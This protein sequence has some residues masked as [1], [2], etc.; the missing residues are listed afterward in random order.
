MSS[1]TEGTIGWR[2]RNLYGL[3]RQ[4][5]LGRQSV[6]HLIGSGV[7][8]FSPSASSSSG[9]GV[10]RNATGTDGP[11]KINPTAIP[12]YPKFFGIAV[13]KVLDGAAGR[14][15]VNPIDPL[16]RV[17]M[18]KEQARIKGRVM[19]RK[20]YGE[21]EDV[22]PLLKSPVL[23]PEPGE[24]TDMDSVEI[25]GLGKR[26]R[27]A[28]EGEMT[29]EYISNANKWEDIKALAARDLVGKG[30]AVTRDD[31]E[32]PFISIRHVDGRNL[33]ISNC[34]YPDFSDI[35]H[36][37][38]LRVLTVPQLLAAIPQT[39]SDKLK[40]AFGE[41]LAGVLN[42]VGIVQ[43]PNLNENTFMSG[44]K[45]AILDLEIITSDPEAREERTNKH[46]NI[47][48]GA[49]D[50]KKNTPPAGGKIVRRTRMGLY[51]CK[52]VVGTDIVYDFGPASAQKRQLYGGSANPARV[53]SSFNIVAGDMEDMK[54][55][56]RT[57]AV[58]G[59]VDAM[60]T[61]WYRLQHAIN[62][63]VPKGFSIDVDAI[64]EIN[65]EGPNGKKMGPN[66]IM[67]LFFSRGIL[68]H[69]SSAISDDRQVR[70]SIEVLSGKMDG[71]LQE[72]WTSFMNCMEIIRQTMG[73]NEQT[74]ASSA[75]PKALTTL[76]N[77]AEAG[78][79]NALS[80]LI[81]AIQRLQVQ[82]C[83]SVML[84]AQGLVKSA[85]LTGSGD[86]EL[87][88][89][90]LGQGT[91][92]V[93]SEGPCIDRYTLGAVIEAGPTNE[94]LTLFGE[95]LTMSVQQALITPADINML[96]TIKN[97]KQRQLF[98]DVRIKQAKEAQQQEKKADVEYNAQVQ[99]QSAQAAEE[100][101]RQTAK[102][103]FDLDV[104]LEKLKAENELRKQDLIGRYANE[105]DR[106]RATGY[107]EAGFIQAKSRDTSNARD[108]YTS[109]MEKG[110]PEIAATITTDSSLESRAND[111]R[112]FNA[113][114]FT[115]N[116]EDFQSRA[117]P[118]T[119][120]GQELE[121]PQAPEPQPEENPMLR[122]GMANS[123]ASGEQPSQPSQPGYGPGATGDPAA[124]MQQRMESGQPL[125]D[126]E[127]A[128]GEDAE[129]DEGQGQEE[130]EDDQVA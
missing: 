108:N 40:G 91:A 57:E 99:Q 117:A 95:A 43:A 89:A 79:N 58:T 87:I 74:D 78:T 85:R 13:K 123:V 54:P 124:V 128:G 130:W 64:A 104:A 129:E 69:S 111:A 50:P 20:V 107:S 80:D 26:H 53:F 102:M 115:A 93:L 36:I 48:F 62:I 44:G 81:R 94:D 27:S 113:P 38:E 21:D 90:A 70:K 47:V 98:L 35:R 46:G 110:L 75:N 16:A 63:H 92:S 121:V 51:K 12:V 39:A 67:R 71:E 9:S 5:E 68:L 76:A 6:G 106:I 66:E 127:Q 23:A 73:L 103:Q 97:F 3:L 22:K 65:I 119:A 83:E 41:G 109:L 101:R 7:D 11:A 25:Y 2:S 120:G 112:D 84:R 49:T 32:G 88:V 18:E 126:Q 29:W 105:S 33:V 42:G 122:E 61:A 125:F 59:A 14:L 72:F 31:T 4:Y 100:Q 52:W 24:P 34:V 15:S 10:K 82:Q 17:E 96:N 45:V 37:G 1:G 116:A 55:F 8:V 86:D 28:M 77:Q 60:L 118:L 56:S 114:N 19:L 30:F